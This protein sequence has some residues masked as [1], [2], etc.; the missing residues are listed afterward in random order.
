MNMVWYVPPHKGGKGNIK[1]GYLWSIKNRFAV[2]KS[3]Y[4]NTLKVFGERLRF[5]PSLATIAI[6]W[7]YVT[8]EFEELHAPLDL[9]ETGILFISSSVLSFGILIMFNHWPMLTKLVQ[10]LIPQQINTRDLLTH[11][12]M[13]ASASSD[14]LFI[15]SHFVHVKKGS[16]EIYLLMHRELRFDRISNETPCN[17]AKELGEEQ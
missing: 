17:R 8:R 10:E 15:F 1:G 7:G 14:I 3:S 11:Q 6:I 5:V 9:D 4:T 2:L 13:H 16:F 12:R